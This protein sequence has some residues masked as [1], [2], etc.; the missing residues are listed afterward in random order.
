[1][2][3]EAFTRCPICKEPFSGARGLAHGPMP[4]EP[5]EYVFGELVGVGAVKHYVGSDQRWTSK[6]LATVS[7]EG[8]TFV[9]EC[10]MRLGDEFPDCYCDASAIDTAILGR[11]IW[12]HPNTRVIGEAALARA[13]GLEPRLPIDLVF[14]RPGPEFFERRATARTH[15]R[16]VAPRAVA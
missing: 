13:A 10:L 6:A 3:S 16:A 11:L 2:K 1:M 7:L 14:V 4:C 9:V 12:P 8:R 15:L 5:V